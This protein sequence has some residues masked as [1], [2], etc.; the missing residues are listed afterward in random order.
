MGLEGE[1]VLVEI[2]HFLRMNTLL[3]GIYIRGMDSVI[4]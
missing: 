2:S 3:Q 1:S 4:I